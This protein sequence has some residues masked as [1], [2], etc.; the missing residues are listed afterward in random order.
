MP[1]LALSPLSNQLSVPL[2]LG[3]PDKSPRSTTAETLRRVFDEID[4][5]RDGSISL[6]E[7]KRA[8]AGRKKRHYRSLLS[9]AGV[10]WNKAFSRL[11]TA[12]VTFED[13]KAASCGYAETPTSPT[14]GM[15]S[16]SRST[17]NM[18]ITTPSR[19]APVVLTIERGAGL[20]T[21]RKSS[22]LD[23]ADEACVYQIVCSATDT[24]H[25]VKTLIRDAL[26]EKHAWPETSPWCS[27]A[28]L[29][30]SD[31]ETSFVCAIM[32]LVAENSH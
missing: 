11:S 22:V 28:S 26:S 23:G 2:G 8:L 25:H 4:L 31:W 7:F 20:R 32:G 30:G 17:Y 24:V 1:G 10:D 9:M 15:T 21:Q 14:H 19:S 6:R 12:S 5:D 13:F 29:R 3:S 18:C 27:C 16:P